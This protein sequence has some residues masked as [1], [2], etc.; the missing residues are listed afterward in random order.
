[1]DALLLSVG[2]LEQS[3]THE[4]H[5]LSGHIVGC[6]KCACKNILI[7]ARRRKDARMNSFDI[8][9]QSLT[10]DGGNSS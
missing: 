3:P 1:M 7:D 5:A 4:G 2:P 6:P 9:L 10:R 8:T